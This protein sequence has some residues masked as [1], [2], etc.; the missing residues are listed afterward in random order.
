MSDSHLPSITVAQLGARRRY[1]VPRAL[2]QANRLHTLYTD[3]Y[4]TDTLAKFIAK[5]PTPFKPDGLDRFRSRIIHDI[6]KDKITQFPF[7]GYKY[8][9]RCRDRNRADSNTDPF[10]WGGRRF[11]E[12]VIAT[13]PPPP[14]TSYTFS[15]AGLELMQH[16]KRSG[17]SC[18]SDQ[19]ILPKP[20]ERKWIDPEYDAFPD[21]STE[22]QSPR[23]STDYEH[24]ESQEWALADRIICGAPFVRDAL[25]QAGV[26]PSKITTVHPQIDVQPPAPPST[27]AGDE[28][29][30]VLFAGTLG[31]RKGLPYLAQALALCNS[32]HIA[33]RAVG[34]APLTPAAINDISR[35]MTVVGPVSY[36]QMAFEYAWADVLVLP[37]LAEG[38]ARACA[39]ALAHGVPVITTENAGSVVRHER[40]GFLTPVRSPDSI[41]EK[42]DL[43]A[44]NP[45]LLK[46][47]SI[48]AQQRASAYTWSRYVNELIEATTMGPNVTPAT[49]T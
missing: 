23:R 39:E 5:L 18:I 15:S 14:L 25:I 44:S 36:S 10:L 20:I 22:P 17:G 2:H 19:T 48:N 46:E 30:R 13:L 41:A 38:A 31:L 6:P 4:C 21:W 33:C 45:S 29:L 47:L 9:S 28:T 1:A 43:L 42:L 24:R 34:H 3:L 40:D 49:A 37:T 32:K 7:F 11:C 12:R 26:E 8:Y 35:Y 27:P 16:V